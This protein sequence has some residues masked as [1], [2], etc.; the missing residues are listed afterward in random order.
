MMEAMESL[1]ILAGVMFWS[2]AD[3][4]LGLC[5]LTVFGCLIMAVV[6]GLRK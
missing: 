3:V 2:M 1:R 5:W 6:K 4:F